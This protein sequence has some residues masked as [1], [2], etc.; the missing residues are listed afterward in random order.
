MIPFE[1][2]Y[3]ICVN[4][5]VRGRRVETPENVQIGHA[6]AVA[7]QTIKG[8]DRYAVYVVVLWDGTECLMFLRSYETPE[9]AAAKVNQLSALVTSES[10][11]RTVPTADLT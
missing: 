9:R 5:P 7:W 1:R 4:G 6:C 10:P 11:L 3:L 8:A 2:Q